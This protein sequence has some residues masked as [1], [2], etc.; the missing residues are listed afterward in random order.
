M[1]M[2][3]HERECNDRDFIEAVLEKADVLFLAM[4]DH[5]AP[6]CIPVNYGLAQN[7]IY[8]HCAPEGLKLEC[9]RLNPIVAFS[10]AVDIEIDPAK[11]TTWYQSVAGRGL[12]AIITDECEKRDG[13][14]LIGRRY[15][16]LCRQPANLAR[17]TIIRVTITEISGKRHVKA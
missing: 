8:I 2:R 17:V 11:A 7:S 16:A 14:E 15:K 4:L 5:G 13:L 12:A 1:T 3:R 10:A 6:Y 9:I